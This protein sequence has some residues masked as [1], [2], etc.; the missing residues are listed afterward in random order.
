MRRNDLAGAA[1]PR[2]LAVLLFV[3][4]ALVGIPTP[5]HADVEGIPCAAEPTDE[6]IQYGDLITCDISPK[7]DSDLFRFQGTAGEHMFATSGRPSGGVSPCLQLIRPSGGAPFASSCTL[8][9]SA[10]TVAG[11][12]DETGLWTIAVSDGGNNNIGP[13]TLVLDRL[14][15]ASPAA[16][17]L[18]YGATI[19]GEINPI[20]DADLFL[21]GGGLGST[22]SIQTAK[23]SGT[24]RPCIFLYDPDGALVA[25][26]CHTVP[27]GS[28]FAITAT[29]VTPGAHTVY[30]A[31]RANNELGTYS[32]TIQCLAGT[33]PNLHTVTITA[34][35]AGTPNPVRQTGTAS[36]DVTAIDTFNHPL[37]YAWTASCA[38]PL[39]SN[40]SFSNASARNPTWTAP[41]NTTGAEQ[42][43]TMHVAVSDGQGK[44]A[45]G[46]YDQHVYPILPPDITVT[47]LSLAFGSTA[48]GSP[49]PAQPVTI[50]NIGLTDDLLIKKITLGGTAFTAVGCSDTTLGPGQSC[51]VSVVF[52]PSSTGLKTS[53][54]SIPS[55]DPDT[56]LVKVSLSGTATTA[57]ATTPN[58]KVTPPSLAF[59]N[60]AVGGTSGALVV[61]I[62]ND[63]T[64]T[65][66]IKPITLKGTFP[67]SFKTTADTC[68]SQGL[69]HLQSCTVSV[70]FA[71]VSTGLKSAL[72]WI[73]SNDPDV[74]DNPVKLPLSGT[75][76]TGGGG[77]PDI[78]V[79]P[80]SLS[81][82][83]IAVGATSPSQPVT[84]TNSG[85]ANLLVKTIT[86][87]GTAPGSFLTS[88]DGCSN[89]TL[90][91]TQSCTVSVAFK[92]ASGG[93]KSA[94]LSIL[95]NDPDVAQNPLKVPLSGTGTTGGG[96]SAPD[97]T[98]TPPSLDFGSTAVGVESPPQQVTIT[99]SGTANLLIKAI[100]RK[101]TAP[102]SFLTSADGCSYTTL[103]PTQ[104]CTVSVTF[105]P[106]SIGLKS[107]EL[108]IPSND[109]DVAQNPL[110]VPLSGTGTTGGGGSGPKITV[111]PPSLDFG[112]IAV[113]S[114][115][116]PQ[117]VTV[118]NDGDAPLK[119]TT[120]KRTG[121]FASSYIKPTADD[122]CTNQTLAPGASCTVSVFFKP[123]S[124][125]LKP[126]QLAIPSNDP[127]PA[128]NPVLVGLSGSGL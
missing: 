52:K 26:D 99:N 76:T 29:I 20:G 27:A 110:K 13:Y 45:E 42:L 84:I 64:G 103:T 120:V 60:T 107:A 85:T 61:T 16:E 88:A 6:T 7:G 58:I 100:T 94:E 97:I 74:A 43:C 15:P 49:S 108:S 116:P 63:G 93:L 71:P 86:R 25:S 4:L 30:I 5:A 3:Y 69:A 31:D 70:L 50:K 113:G 95:S 32:L 2:S 90:T 101:G 33:C 47:P 34:G 9:G 124:S 91:P 123:T 48:V 118:T 39:L 96:G 21:I 83:S 78:T 72:L 67:S 22:I 79:S 54:L 36:L 62:T 28:S 66:T 102:G 117:Q 119:I 38:A 11:V 114:P 23:V 127:D 24:V 51:T 77:T 87:R 65:L 57:G 40:G 92:P 53:L 111:T 19:T 10:F 56:S 18:D 73:P 46:S 41:A 106:A 59:P 75:G 105:K 8:A 89:T 122:H 55:N 104:S 80:L 109:P 44:S 126:A 121:T 81:F 68:S 98:V 125:G 128:R 17:P 12:L 35:P 37:T 14:S 82:G 115:T 112:S 1:L